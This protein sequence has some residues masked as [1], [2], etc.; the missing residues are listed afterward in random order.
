MTKPSESDAPA[1]RNHVLRFTSMAYQMALSIG[2]G[3]WGGR[4][5]DQYLELETPWLTILG[6]L[7]GTSAAFYF[8]LKEAAK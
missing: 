6:S 4:K 3:V 2:I 1:R 5:A 8:V 7:L